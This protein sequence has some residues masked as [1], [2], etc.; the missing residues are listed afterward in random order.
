MS[1]TNVSNRSAMRGRIKA[2]AAR[3]L[4]EL[5]AADATE[6]L[7][8]EFESWLQRDPE[9]RRAY[10]RAERAWRAL[11]AV[12]S[13]RSTENSST[14]P[15]G[16]VFDRNAKSTRHRALQPVAMIAAIAAAILVALV[17]LSCT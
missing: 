6:R 10:V 11:G 12:R 16:A 13:V 17:F 1:T 15:Q 8:Y 2:E 5:D 3:W 14:G 4:I 7:W 9:H